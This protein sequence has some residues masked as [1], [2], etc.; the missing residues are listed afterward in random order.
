[1]PQ[2]YVPCEWPCRLQKSKYPHRTFP[3]I[4]IYVLLVLDSMCKNSC[5]EWGRQGRKDGGERENNRLSL[6]LRQTLWLERKT[7]ARSQIPLVASRYRSQVSK[8]LYKLARLKLALRDVKDSHYV[9]LLYV[10]ACCQK[11]TYRPLAIIVVLDV[12]ARWDLTL[13]P[14][15]PL[16]PITIPP[17][18]VCVMGGGMQLKLAITSGQLYQ[19]ETRG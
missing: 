6:L 1:M 4:F 9:K 17:R 16:H 10:K 2:T 7:R 5:L 3:T 11:R 15:P 13:P 19:E 18:S 12:C 14:N 8:A